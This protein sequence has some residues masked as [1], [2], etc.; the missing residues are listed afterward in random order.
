MTLVAVTTALLGPDGAG[1]AVLLAQ[2]IDEVTLNFDRAS[3]LLLNAIIGLIMFGVALDVNV[4]DL[5]DVLRRP[6]APLIG[7]GSQFLL[8]PAGTF[9]LTRLLDPTPSIALGMILVS[10]CP[11][12]NVSNIITHLAKGNTGLSIGMTGVSTLAA[13][14]LTPLNFAFWGSLHPATNELLRSVAVSPVELAITIGLLLAVPVAAGVTVRSRRPDLARRLYRP[15]RAISIAFFLAFIAI[16]FVS[17]IEHFSTM[18]GAV[19]LAVLLHNALAL[20]LGYTAGWAAGLDER[21]RRA[22]SIEVGIQ[23][24]ALAL[25]LIFSFFGGLGG[26]AL[27]AAWWGIWHILAGL[28]L[29][30]VWSRRPTDDPSPLEAVGS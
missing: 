1:G 12:G 17:N 26:M 21:D 22:T 4:T 29:A 16:A 18:L 27:V 3:L 20:T 15:V 30:A 25:V 8:L 13:A 10:C 6:K 9:L 24:S 2:A 19:A 23:N 7:V 5:R 11:G 14:V 28:G